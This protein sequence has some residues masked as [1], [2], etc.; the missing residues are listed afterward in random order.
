MGT[1]IK[2][3]VAK[4]HTTDILV[5]QLNQLLRDRLYGIYSI[6]CLNSNGGEIDMSS[7]KGDDVVMRLHIHYQ[8]ETNLNALCTMLARHLCCGE[9]IAFTYK[10]YHATEPE[11]FRIYK[12][13]NVDW[14]IT[15]DNLGDFLDKA[16]VNSNMRTLYE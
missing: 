14:K 15:I 2:T 13:S 11:V 5:G 6:N 16:M 7:L 8:H 9:S 4:F 1:L 10:E 3:T 12:L